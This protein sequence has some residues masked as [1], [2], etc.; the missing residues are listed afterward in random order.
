MKQELKCIL[1]I[2][3]EEVDNFIHEKVIKNSGCTE[4]IVVVDGGQPALDYLVAA[5]DGNHPMPDLIF[6][7]INMP[8]M[9]GWEFIEAYRQLNK[10]ED[11]HVIIAM[12]TTSLNPDDAEKAKTIKEIKDFINKPLTTDILQEILKKHWG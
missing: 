4:K 11:E 8:G 5:K 2:D 3:D 6:L 1:L 10:A 7:D 12:L 9:D